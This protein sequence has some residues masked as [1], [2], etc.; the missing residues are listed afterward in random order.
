MAPI[1]PGLA[2]LAG[3]AV[4]ALAACR[5]TTGPAAPE[6]LGIIEFYG[7][8]TGVL[9]LPESVRAGHD[10]TVTVRTFGGGCVSAAGTGVRYR[11]ALAVVLP[12]DNPSSRAPAGTGCLDVLLRPLHTVNLRFP[13]PGRA[14]VRVEGRREPGGGSTAVEGTLTVTAP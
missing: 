7:D 13:T 11:G 6:E 14:T 9:E 12:Y 10:V 3:F 8:R 5:S 2:C 4:A 1:A